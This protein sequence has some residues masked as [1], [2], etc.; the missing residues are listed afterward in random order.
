LKFWNILLK[1]RPVARFDL[2][3]E[4]SITIGRTEE[5]GVTL[6]NPSI[7]RLHAV[8]E[9]ESGCAYI[10][11]LGSTNGT[12]VNGEKIN[13]RTPISEKDEIKIGKFNLVAGDEGD[14]DE[15]GKSW[16]IDMD[17]DRATIFV[18]RKKDK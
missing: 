5:A 2:H 15:T 3:D 9:L 8:V 13:D 4:G 11:D 7:S 18:P 1:D 10:T 6:D 16:V 17:S 12:W 14:F